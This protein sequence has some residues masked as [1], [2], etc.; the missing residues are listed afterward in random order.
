MVEKAVVGMRLSPEELALL[1]VLAAH[2]E[3]TRSDVA[4]RGGRFAPTP[5]SSG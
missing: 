1:D 2:E 4:R 3:R 5:K